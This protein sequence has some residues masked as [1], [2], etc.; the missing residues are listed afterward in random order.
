MHNPQNILIVGGGQAGGQLLR[1][2]IAQGDA[3][4][5]TLATAEHQPPYER[6]PLSK[7]F[8]KGEVDF[9]ALRI[10][11]A[12]ELADPRLTTHYGETL[13]SVDPDK[14]TA[15]FAS[16]LVLGYDKLVLALGAR[17]RKLPIA[18]AEY[19]IELRDLEDSKILREKL[20]SA[21]HVTI[22]GGGVIGLEV[23][24]TARLLGKEVCILEAGAAVMGRI[25]PPVLSHWLQSRHEAEGARILTQSAV[26]QISAAQQGFAVE[27]RLPDG[28]LETLRSDIVLSAIGVVPNVEALPQSCIGPSGGITT[29]ET[30]KVIGLDDIYAIGD[31]AE[32]FNALY[33]RHLRLETW[34]NADSHG[35][36][37]AH[38]LLGSPQPHVETPWMW[39][40]Q[41]DVNLQAVGLWQEGS[42]LVQRGDIGAAGSTT[43]WLSDGRVTGGVLINNG[44]DRRFLEKLLTTGA[45]PD[46]ALLADPNIPMKSIK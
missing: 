16:G 4:H 39:S 26:Q 25:L 44:K 2:L 32:C 46:P 30:G 5:I 31:M 34:R 24:A 28:S 42:T 45:S 14:K 38:T 21:A 10:V 29:D 18:G 35:E 8:L 40:D 41:Y 43:F 17:G 15:T 12:D 20:H 9:D 3:P 33:G 27:I 37:L 19:C 22:I 13:Q 36:A 23:A 6:P 7:G 11:S 1:R